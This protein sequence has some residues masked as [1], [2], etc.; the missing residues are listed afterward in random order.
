MYSRGYAIA[1]LKIANPIRGCVFVGGDL[2]SAPHLGSGPLARTTPPLFR[3]G[4]DPGAPVETAEARILNH[5][6]TFSRIDPWSL[7]AVSARCL[8]TEVHALYA[9]VARR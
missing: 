3:R 7:S 2:S 6:L 8:R 9:R 1:S 5:S 4:R